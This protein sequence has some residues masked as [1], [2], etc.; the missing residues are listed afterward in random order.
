LTPSQHETF[1]KGLRARLL[2]I[3]LLF[4]VLRSAV[5]EKEMW[6]TY[7]KSLYNEHGSKEKK[8]NS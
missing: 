3:L 4:P 1:Q 7:I 2:T 5:A 6:E 8:Q